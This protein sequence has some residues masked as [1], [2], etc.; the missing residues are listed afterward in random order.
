MKYNI[1]ICDQT[2]KPN[3]SALGLHMTCKVPTRSPLGYT[4][5]ARVLA[6]ARQG[7]TP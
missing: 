1:A 7:Q 3:R 5:A 4:A 6:L 2:V